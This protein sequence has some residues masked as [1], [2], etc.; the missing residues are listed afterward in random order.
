MVERRTPKRE[1]GGSRPIAVVL[2]PESTGNTQEAAAVP[3]H[4]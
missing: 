1:V 4:D 2:C 3:R